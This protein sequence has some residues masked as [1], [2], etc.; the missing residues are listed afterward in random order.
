MDDG[1]KATEKEIR[2]A[3]ERGTAVE[4]DEE[5]AASRCDK[6]VWVAAWVFVPK[7]LLEEQT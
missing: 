1:D 4:I 7:E 6:G 3:R 2:L 5:A